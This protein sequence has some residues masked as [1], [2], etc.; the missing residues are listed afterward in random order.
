M[1]F[2]VKVRLSLNPVRTRLVEPGE[3]TEQ[4]AAAEKPFTQ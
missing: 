1:T 3:Q 2:S 4:E